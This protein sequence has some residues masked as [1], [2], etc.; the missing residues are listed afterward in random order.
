MRGPVALSVEVCAVT[1]THSF[2]FYEENPTFLMG[3]DLISAAALV[4]DPVNRCVWSKRSPTAVGQPSSKTD[5]ASC[6]TSVKVV[7]EQHASCCPVERLYAVPMKGRSY[8]DPPCSTHSFG[9]RADTTPLSPRAPLTHSTL[10]PEH[11]LDLIRSP[12]SSSENVASSSADAS[13]LASTLS[14]IHI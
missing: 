1:L 14:L 5:F 13:L 12:T 7:D 8:E 4:I 11:G 10:A 3:Y 9:P 6:E 2:Y